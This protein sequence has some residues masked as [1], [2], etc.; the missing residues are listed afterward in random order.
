MTTVREPDPELV[1]EVATALVAGGRV[2]PGLAVEADGRSRSWWWPL[3][4]ASHRSLVASLVADPSTDGQRRAATLLAEAVDVI[5]RE[6]LAAAKVALTP[7]R[8]GRPTVT[9]AWAR[10]LASVDPWLPPTLDPAKV[11]A[12]ADEVDAWVRTGAVLGGRVRLCLR[13]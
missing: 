10:S 5:V 7:K 9:E 8:G 12:L 1:L 4:A 6:R 11:R 3:P 2:V 13:V